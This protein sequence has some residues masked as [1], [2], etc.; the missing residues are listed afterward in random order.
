MPRPA[1]PGEIAFNDHFD[2]AARGLLAPNR[3]LTAL[4]DG[5][6]RRIDGRDEQE[7]YDRTRRST[8]RDVVGAALG[9]GTWAPV[10]LLRKPRPVG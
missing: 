1:A 2:A 10:A 8:F 3:L 7:A 4:H 6:R 5:V 9:A